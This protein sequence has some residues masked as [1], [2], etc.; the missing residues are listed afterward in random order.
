MIRER[1]SAD[2]SYAVYMARQAADI[3]AYQRDQAVTLPDSLDLA[4]VIGL[5][6][7]LRGKLEEARPATLAQ[8]SRIEGMTPTALTLLA[9]YA[10]GSRRGNRFADVPKGPQTSKAS[11]D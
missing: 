5:S 2:A 10:R 7:E 11:G 8:A 9:A 4:S 3:A 6:N 1:V